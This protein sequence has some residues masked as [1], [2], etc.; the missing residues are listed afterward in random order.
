MLPNAYLNEFFCANFRS[1]DA[2]NDYAKQIGFVAPTIGNHYESKF[3]SEL[4]ALCVP[5]MLDVYMKGVITHV[6]LICETC[7]RFDFAK[8]NVLFSD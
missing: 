1:F 8:P 3:R 5:R 7:I 2:E 6:I 4:N